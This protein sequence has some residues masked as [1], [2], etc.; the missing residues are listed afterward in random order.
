[1]G[2]RF[3]PPQKSR[4]PL[5][6]TATTLAAVTAY[7]QDVVE[8]GYDAM[9][10]LYLSTFGDGIADDPRVR[11]ITGLADH[12]N[13][14]APVLELGCGAGAPATEL[15]AQ[16]FDVLGVDISAAQLA[17]AAERVP[18]ARFRKADMTK[19]DLP[20]SSFDAIT[21]FYCFNHIPLA[22]QPALFA[23]TAQWLRPGGLLLASFGTGGSNDEIEHW[24]GVSM[25]F[26]SHTPDTN[27]HHLAEAGFT[28][29]IDESVTTIGK[30]GT[31]TF[32]WIL[33]RARP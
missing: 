21:A 19:L 9:A 25:F 24:L 10:E 4:G 2:C 14:G 16:R 30:L 5:T 28:L 32:Q 23:K 26:A 33:A 27:R 7:P 18:N 11:F 29:L 12:L 13:D 20:A 15:L 31:E 1:M 17:L 6:A 3:A 22:E 8:S